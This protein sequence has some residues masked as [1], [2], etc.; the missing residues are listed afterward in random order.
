MAKSDVPDP[1][2]MKYTVLS[3]GAKGGAF[4]NKECFGLNVAKK[5]DCTGDRKLISVK[6]GKR[7]YYNCKQLSTN[8]HSKL[9]LC[10]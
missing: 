2:M 3:V 10:R 8:F 4:A 7:A 6:K 1:T 5:L 9:I